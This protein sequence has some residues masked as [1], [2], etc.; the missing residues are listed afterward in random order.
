MYGEINL[1]STFVQKKSTDLTEKEGYA[2][3]L[4]GSEVT[5]EGVVELAGENATDIAIL[6]E[7]PITSSIECGMTGVVK[8]FAR[9]KLGADSITYGTQLAVNSSGLLVAVDASTHTNKVA[10]AYGNGGKDELIRVLI[11]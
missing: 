7:P 11:V 8:G 6:V 10:V 1:T 2:I 4:N 5:Q 3:V 9:A